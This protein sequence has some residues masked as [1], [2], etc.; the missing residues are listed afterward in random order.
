VGT[1]TAIP[2]KRDNPYPVA[3][4]TAYRRVHKHSYNAK[5]NKFFRLLRETPN[6]KKNSFDNPCSQASNKE[7]ADPAITQSGQF[8]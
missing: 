6:G 1:G 8:S 5:P 2:K 3:R 7:K 4:V